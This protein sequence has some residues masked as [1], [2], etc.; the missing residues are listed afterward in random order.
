SGPAGVMVGAFQGL[1]ST[2][3]SIRNCTFWAV[4]RNRSVRFWAEGIGPIEFIWYHWVLDPTVVGIGVNGIGADQLMPPSVL[5]S[6]ASSLPSAVTVF[7]RMPNEIS[8]L[9][10]PKVLI[11]LIWK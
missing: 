10:I 7:F 9:L 4:C 3:S 11:S 5:A 1:R 8:R 6:T 2:M